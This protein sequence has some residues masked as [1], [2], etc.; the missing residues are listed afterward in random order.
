MV[1]LIYYVKSIYLGR[2]P[3]PHQVLHDLEGGLKSLAFALDRTCTSVLLTYYWRKLRNPTEDIRNETLRI[4]TNSH[5]ST[6]G[7]FVISESPL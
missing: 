6:Q 2:I 3:K 4:A 5:V 7:Y 1:A